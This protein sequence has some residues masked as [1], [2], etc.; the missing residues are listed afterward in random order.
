MLDRWCSIW[1]NLCTLSSF[2]VYYV[3]FGETAPKWRSFLRRTYVLSFRI[4]DMTSRTASISVNSP[5]G[6]LIHCLISWFNVSLLQPIR[7]AAHKIASRRLTSRF[8]PTRKR[9]SPT[10]SPHTTNELQKISKCFWELRSPF[11]AMGRKRS[12]FI[13]TSSCPL[14]RRKG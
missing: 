11:L 13:D 8:S 9:L 7:G 1:Q 12:S 14:K 6:S 10:W 3:S 2:P 4:G 5:G